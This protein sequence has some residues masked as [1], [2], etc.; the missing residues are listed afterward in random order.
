MSEYLPAVWWNS[1]LVCSRITSS[2]CTRQTSSGLCDQMVHTNCKFRPSAS[3]NT[4][5][6]S[7]GCYI[8][9]QQT[10][11]PAPRRLK[12]KSFIWSLR[13]NLEVN[14]SPRVQVKLMFVYLSTRW[15]YEHNVTFLSFITLSACFNVNEEK[16]S[17]MSASNLPTVINYRK[18]IA[19]NLLIYVQTIIAGK[20]GLFELNV[21]TPPSTGKRR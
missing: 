9:Q 18:I 4:W 10:Q 20:Q 15:Q 11:L 17:Q 14:Q 8:N 3:I 21:A 19:R 1:Y 2:W 5:T 13:V 7:N 6:V 12:E 16:K